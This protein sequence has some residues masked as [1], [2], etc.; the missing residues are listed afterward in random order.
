[1]GDVCTCDETNNKSV[2]V[3]VYNFFGVDVLGPWVAN[4]ESVLMSCSATVLLSAS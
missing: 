3:C 4:V 2:D 1:M